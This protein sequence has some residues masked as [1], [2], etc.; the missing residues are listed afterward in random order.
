VTIGRDG[1]NVD[2]TPSTVVDWQDQINTL[3]NARARVGLDDGSVLN[4]GSDSLMRVIK[5]D[6]GVQQT[7]LELTY[8][9][10]R[11]RAQKIVKTNGKFQVR[12]GVGI[13]GV[14]GTDFYTGYDRGVM[15]VLVFEG[16]VRVCNLAGECVLLKAG[17]MTTV[18]NDGTPPAPPA[19]ASLDEMT[20]AAS[21]TDDG[22]EASAETTARNPK[23]DTHPSAGGHSPIGAGSNAFA[24]Y[25]VG[26]VAVVTAIALHKAYESP[27]RP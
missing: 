12:T 7:E 5:H 6:A 13:A 14:V 22:G 1:K 26:V 21:D 4:V 15:S 27:D 11:T 2:A 24:W 23:V 10:L 8:G 18:R 16:L 3:A 19:P 9:K 20:S 17:E 25:A